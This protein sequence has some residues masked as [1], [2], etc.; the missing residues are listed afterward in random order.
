MPFGRFGVAYPGLPHRPRLSLNPLDIGQGKD[1]ARKAGANS[2]GVGLH[3]R[4]TEPVHHVCGCVQTRLRTRRA[5]GAWRT[6]RERPVICHLSAALRTNLRAML[7]MTVGVLN[8]MRPHHGF[9]G[10]DGRS[11]RRNPALNERRYGSRL[12]KVRGRGRR[13]HGLQPRSRPLSERSPRRSV[14]RA[15]AHSVRRTG[16]APP[17]IMEISCG[18]ADKSARNVSTG[19]PTSLPAEA[20]VGAADA[21]KTRA[22]VSRIVGAVR[23]VCDGLLERGARVGT[24]RSMDPLAI[25]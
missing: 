11:P 6:G 8:R 16:A 4:W 18:L 12:D 15:F 13:Y 19:G 25:P 24:G 2:F 3:F 23:R 5:Q 1:S 7:S 20:G 9:S 22:G 14:K 17:V 10:G 21:A